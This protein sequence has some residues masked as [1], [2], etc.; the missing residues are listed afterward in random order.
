MP[1]GVLSRIS[2]SLSQ[3]GKCVSNLRGFAQSDLA[4][5]PF[6]YIKPA[7]R[8]SFD[9]DLSSI[10]TVGA[11]DWTNT[12][13]KAYYST[14]SEGSGAFRYSGGLVS[15][16]ITG[17]ILFRMYIQTWGDPSLIPPVQTVFRNGTA[18]TNGYGIK[19]TYDEVVPE[20]FEWNL[21][22]CRLQDAQNSWIKL[23]QSGPLQLNTW[24]QFSVRFN[25]VIDK[26]DE[27]TEVVAYQN[28]SYQL[29]SFMNGLI[30]T[31]TAGITAV[32]EFYG[33]ITDF[34]LLE[35]QLTN[36]QLAAY[37]T[38]PYI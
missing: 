37:G 13:Q 20:E 1:I 28:G 7:R 3:G 34:A 29:L 31:P 4:G 32:L 14:D 33:R 9:A 19:L 36:V 15:S 18:A 21:Y 12:I 10:S 23:N 27:V 11:G 24:Y 22:F 26:G 6:D 25:T 2:N 38:A 17:T 30:T 16:A 35:S 8:F 5:E